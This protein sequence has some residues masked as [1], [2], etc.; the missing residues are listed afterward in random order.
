MI[1]KTTSYIVANEDRAICYLNSEISVILLLP[2]QVILLLPSQDIWICM[3]ID[4]KLCV[5]MNMI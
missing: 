3:M 5:L 1:C 4:V 2:S